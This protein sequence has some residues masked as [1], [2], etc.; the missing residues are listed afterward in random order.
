LEFEEHLESSALVDEAVDASS[1]THEGIGSVD[2]DVGIEVEEG[3][4]DDGDIGEAHGGFEI[5]V[6]RWRL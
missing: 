3:A 6:R 5:T 2:D 4:T 1:A